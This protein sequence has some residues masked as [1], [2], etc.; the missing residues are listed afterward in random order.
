MSIFRQ[1]SLREGSD[2]VPATFSG[3]LVGIP[4]RLYSESDFYL[5]VGMKG[6]SRNVDRELKNELYMGG[7]ESVGYVRRKLECSVDAADNERAD[8]FAE[9]R[10]KR[11]DAGYRS[12]NKVTVNEMSATDRCCSANLRSVQIKSPESQSDMC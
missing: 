6:W 9:G 10:C 8:V 2:V 11:M 1:W 4:L 12:S 5:F 3:V 7:R